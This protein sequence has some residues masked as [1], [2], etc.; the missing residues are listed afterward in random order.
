MAIL[1][2]ENLIIPEDN[3]NSRDPVAL[4]M[5]KWFDEP[6][7][8]DM[9]TRLTSV[10]HS[11]TTQKQDRDYHADICYTDPS[12]NMQTFIDAKSV[13][14]NFK[15]IDQSIGRT[16]YIDAIAIGQ[17]ALSSNVNY[18]SFIWRSGLYVV[19]HLSLHTVTPIRVKVSYGQNNH[20]QV[21]SHYSVQSLIAIPDTKHYVIPEPYMKVYDDAYAC[22][23][24]SRNM[25]F[26]IERTVQTEF[27]SS[28]NYRTLVNFARELKPIIVRYN[29]IDNVFGYVEM[30]PCD[31]FKQNLTNILSE[32][33]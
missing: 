5:A 28:V 20:R 7:Q 22:Y 19:Q 18:F 21:L 24:R 29:N 16:S 17:Y 8:A 30:T 31:E 25:M 4:Y 33:L 26:D 32:I 23:E 6:F 10:A 3:I 12:T 13:T 15:Y 2:N 27:R 9:L 14:R 11:L 1:I